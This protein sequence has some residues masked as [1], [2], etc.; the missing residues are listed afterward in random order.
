MANMVPSQ[1]VCKSPHSLGSQ[2]ID[3]CLPKVNLHNLK[4]YTKLT[5]QLQEIGHYFEA[6]NA[7]CL[8]TTN[9]VLQSNKSHIKEHGIFFC[10]Q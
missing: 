1:M 5:F 8:G 10:T 7:V 9:D 2:A 6:T 4:K 3:T